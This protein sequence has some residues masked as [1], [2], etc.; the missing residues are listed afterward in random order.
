MMRFRQR[1]LSSILTVF[2]LLGTLVLTGVHFGAT[3]HYF[4][5]LEQKGSASAQIYRE[6]IRGWLGRYL[7]LAPIYAR[8]PE[9]INLL[10]RPDDGIQIDMVN[11]RLEQWNSASGSADTYVLDN[12][13]T[14]VAASNWNEPYS[15]VGRN[16]AFR[17]YFTDAMQ[18]RLGRFF[19]LGTTSGK[20]GYYFASPVRD[21]GEIVGAVVVKVPVDEIEQELRASPASVFITDGSGVIV[22]AGHPA[23]RLKTLGPLSDTSLSEIRAHR[24][25]ENAA[26][27]PVGFTTV[28]APEGLHLL[29]ALPDRSSD[30]PVEFLHLS[31]PMNV[32]GWRLHLLLATGET[33]RQI[34]TIVLLAAMI[35]LLTLAGAIIIY[36]RRRRLVDRLAERERAE[37]ALEQAVQDRTADLRKTQAELIQAAKLAA[38]GQMSAALS[39]E[40]NQP[41]AAIRSYAENAVAFLERGRREQAEDNLDRIARLT[42]RMAQLSK[43][44]TSFARKPASSLRPVAFEPA[45][46]ET[47]SLLRGRLERAG[48]AL[49]QEIAPDLWVTGGQTR[50]QQVLMN[51]IAN[52]IDA[53]DGQAQPIVG[54]E[55]RQVRGMVEIR[56]SDNGGGIPAEV[57]D[58]L[59]DPFVTTKTEGKGLGLGLSI[60]FNIIRDF[61]GSI[62]AGNTAEGAVFT[63]SLAAA[64]RIPEAAE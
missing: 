34:W 1:P 16:F 48:V 14:T 11:A 56:I 18:G 37:A 53:T 46:E 12:H 64:E 20:R 26:L 29:E 4:Q 36:Q 60:T 47:L 15:F 59:F 5:L 25:F 44:L 7:A 22:L 21:Q 8:N 40:F 17:P 19:A 24:Q 43:H 13:G 54:I 31:T 55:A 51:L 9:I 27:D 32:E 38:L 23:W 30:G 33:R 63:L 61:G 10:R 39:H 28:R 41:L 62:S 52:A 50:L 45:L 58:T 6:V 2:L 57:I 35:G 49:R 3:N 42:Q